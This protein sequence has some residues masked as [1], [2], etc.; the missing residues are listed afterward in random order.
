MLSHLSKECIKR[1]MVMVLYL[2]LVVVKVAKY[3]ILGN[4]LYEMT[5]F[6]LKKNIRPVP[7]LLLLQHMHN[8]RIGW[9]QEEKKQKEWNTSKHAFSF[10]S[11][12]MAG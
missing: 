10:G 2:E 7:L 6:Y 8:N 1:K 11:L 5:G 4:K 12:A 9:W 3:Y